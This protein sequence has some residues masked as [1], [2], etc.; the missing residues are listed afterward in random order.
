MIGRPACFHVTRGGMTANGPMPPRNPTLTLHPARHVA[1]RRSLATHREHRA[2][3]AA[4]IAPV[5]ANGRQRH[6][7]RVDRESCLAGRFEY[8]AHRRQQARQRHAAQAAAH[9]LDRG[10]AQHGARQ[11]H[12]R[13]ADRADLHETQPPAAGRRLRGDN[14]QRLRAGAP[15]IIE[16]DVHACAEMRFERPRQMHVVLLQRHR[17]VRAGTQQ[18]LQRGRVAARRDH[19]RRAEML[20]DPH[21]EPPRRARCA[22]DEH[23]LA[24]DEPRAFGQRRPRRHPGNRDRRGR[25]IVERVRQRHALRIRRDRAFGHRTERRGRTEEVD[26][27]A[28][29]ETPHA[30]DTHNERISANGGIMRTRRT[31][32]RDAAQR[33][34]RHVDQAVARHRARRFELRIN[35]TLSGAFDDCCFHGD[36]FDSGEW[37]LPGIEPCAQRGIAYFQHVEQAE[38]TQ[39]G[40]RIDRVGLRTRP[41]GRGSVR[42]DQ[43]ARV[44]QK[45]A[46]GPLADRR[47]AGID[48]V[49]MVRKH[50]FGSHRV[51][52]RLSSMDAV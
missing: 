29:I 44:D 43:Y 26:A 38:R 50:L 1:I 12:V 6:R 20:R 46:D 24:R 42:V 33:G 34:R 35:R 41:L 48:L 32:L 18:R 11:Q 39:R 21:R 47:S 17:R 40:Q 37:A 27:P 4:R 49:G 51:V 52:L 31:P 5:F 9:Q 15:Q 19:L 8:A 3:D 14:Q 22:I 10:R 36:S 16:H 13:A 25:D 45:R 28:I 7:A 23:R 30:V 2:H